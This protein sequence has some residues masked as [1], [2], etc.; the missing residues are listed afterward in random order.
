MGQQVKAELITARANKLFFY[1]PYNF[2][3]ALNV[4]KQQ[5]LF[6]TGQTERYA[7]DS[8]HR[9][10]EF[11]G[12][13]KTV[14][15]LYT[16]L[17]WDTGFFNAPVYKVF[18]ALFDTTTAAATLATAAVAF[19]QHLQ[20]EGAAYCFAELP[21]EDTCLIQA[22]GTAGWPLIETRLTFFRDGLNDFHHPR[23]PVRSAHQDEAVAIGRIA[24]AARNEHDR[25]HADPWFADDQ[26][27]RFLA[28]YATVAVEGYCDD[29]LVPN[30][31]GLPIDSFLAISDLQSHSASLGAEFSR[32]VLTAVGPANRGWHLKL[33]A[34]TVQRARS[35]GADYVLMTTQAT[36][37]AV[38]RTCEKL[39][40][41]LGSTGC[42]LACSF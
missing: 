15:F 26:G 21:I 2:L 16:Y 35:R 32:V 19:K 13:E 14:Q 34:E 5:R 36:N 41:K 24:A 33:V 9:V 29:V 37:R 12:E 20:Q 8:I 6:G 10:F 7:A 39:G 23:Y 28:R 25:F 1:S 3:R 38:F 11:R 18:T 22:L 31:P 42:I 30:E 27:D 4:E 40:F 17:S